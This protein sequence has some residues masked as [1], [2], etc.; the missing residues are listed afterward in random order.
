MHGLLL[1]LNTNDHNHFTS[2][3]EFLENPLKNETENPETIFAK[4]DALE[5]HYDSGMKSFAK[6]K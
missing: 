5:D 4:E 3:N 1:N 2:L 6:K